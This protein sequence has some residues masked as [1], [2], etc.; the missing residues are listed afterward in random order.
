MSKFAYEVMAAE[1]MFG[2]EYADCAVL[3]WSA[4]GRY[5]ERW[6]KRECKMHR[7]SIDDLAA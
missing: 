5:L 3:L 7:Q 6:P 1:L 4:F 2:E